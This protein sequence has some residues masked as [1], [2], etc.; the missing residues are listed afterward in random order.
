[1]RTRKLVSWV[2]Y[3]AMAHGNAVGGKVVCEQA[4]WDA[5]ERAQPGVHTLIRA[6]IT[7]EGEAEHLARAGT[8]GA[9][10][11]GWNRKH[12]KPTETVPIAPPVPR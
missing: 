9:K 5:L 10:P 1:M 6:G 8:D 12:L 4:E 2:V 7:N 11:A 3:Q